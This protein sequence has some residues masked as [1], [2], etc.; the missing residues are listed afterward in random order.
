MKIRTCIAVMI[1]ALLPSLG[2]AQQP[3]VTHLE[4]IKLEVTFSR[5]SGVNYSRSE[6]EE[7]VRTDLINEAVG[8]GVEVTFVDPHTDLSRRV[9]REQNSNE[10]NR[11]V[12]G[13][14]RRGG[15]LAATTVLQLAV[16]VERS[17]QDERHNADNPLFGGSYDS[18]HETVIVN[19][20]GNLVDVE[21]ASVIEA[22][23][24]D[25]TDSRQTNQDVQINARQSHSLFGGALK[26]L[27][28]LINGR[29]STSNSSRQ[30]SLMEDQ[31]R[32]ACSRLVGQLRPSEEVEIPSH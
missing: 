8:Q 2:N 22:V 14:P 6:L 32:P 18:A 16:S 10:Y 12:H 25:A 19:L 11:R 24:A 4:R 20:Q 9:L 26:Y 13:T 27:A 29:S 17:L 31:L 1:L 7:M 28:P 3:T 21:T 15:F 30:S 23:V 5:V